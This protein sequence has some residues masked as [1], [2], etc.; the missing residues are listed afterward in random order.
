MAGQ[1]EYWTNKSNRLQIEDP[2]FT[3]KM[4]KVL[5]KIMEGRTDLKL[6]RM[7]E[8]VLDIFCEEFPDET[9][10]TNYREDKK[11][12]RALLTTAIRNMVKALDLS[13]YM[14]VFGITD[15]FIFTH[16]KRNIETTDGRVS[17]A[18]IVVALKLKR[19][20]IDGRSNA[21]AQTQINIKE[22][23]FYES[24]A[25]NKKEAMKDLLENY[26]ALKELEHREYNL[27]ADQ[28]TVCGDGEDAM[29]DEHDTS[30]E[31]IHSPSSG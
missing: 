13:D 17:N 20:L 4:V 14:E 8:E 16:L 7:D 24:G 30:G 19:M 5:T 10:V 11:G 26:E 3:P 1:V 23:T 22:A 27:Q 12:S 18:A 29:S 25:R 15:P 31:E 6:H 9:A 28:R 2:A 21:N